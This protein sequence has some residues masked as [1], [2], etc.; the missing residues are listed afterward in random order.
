MEVLLKCSQETLNEVVNLTGITAILMLAQSSQ[1]N[2]GIE[3]RL[4][5]DIIPNHHASIIKTF[6]VI[7]SSY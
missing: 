2:V 5:Y 3:P 6:G 7:G 1:I 4:G